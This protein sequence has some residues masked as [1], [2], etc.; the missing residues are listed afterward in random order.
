MLQKQVNLFTASHSEPLWT[1][2]KLQ[3]PSNLNT[4]ISLAWACKHQSETT[5]TSK[6]T[7]SCSAGRGTNTKAKPEIASPARSRFKRSTIEELATKH[8]EEC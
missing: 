3:C 8:D 4:T 1:D 5:P 2:V 6:N 7:V